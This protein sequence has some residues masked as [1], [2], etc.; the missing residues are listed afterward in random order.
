MHSDIST[1]TPDDIVQCLLDQ[2]SPI[3][4]E[5]FQK[6]GSSLTKERFLSILE[7]LEQ[8]DVSKLSSVLVGL[9]HAVFQD[10][11]YELN[12]Q[13]AQLLK[14]CAKD[15]PLLHQLTLFAH[16]IERKVTQFEEESL[17]I[18]QSISVIDISS[19]DESRVHEIQ[20]TLYE[21]TLS[22]QNLTRSLSNGLLIAWNSNREELIFL[23][24]Q[25][26]ERMLRL[27]SSY[28]GHARHDLIHPTGLFKKLEDR[29][30]TLYTDKLKDNDPAIE[31]LAVLGI[32]YE[33]DFVQAGLLDKSKKDKNF[34]STIEHNL[35]HL[36][37]TTV[38]DIKR[39][40]IYS[41]T[42]LK[43]FIAQARLLLRL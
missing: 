22:I 15:E 10:S 16:E 12:E 32:V 41:R 19:I 18:E 31:A 39:N 33:E 11:L 21:I 36:G 30:M 37:L 5:F 14:Y 40:Q 13:Q 42:S 35:S 38:G 26:K 20:K 8:V 17:V 1:L 3:N 27:E 6:I 23:L 25:L 9:S 28:I 29:L 24:S 43:E 2:K 34:L 4:K 7:K